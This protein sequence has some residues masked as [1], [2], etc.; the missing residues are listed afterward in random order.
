MVLH[1]FLSTG[2]TVALHWYDAGTVLVA[3]VLDS[4]PT[5]F[6][7][8]PCGDCPTSVLGPSVEGGLVCAKVPADCAFAGKGLQLTMLR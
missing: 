8:V 5:V 1:W 3:L 2:A 7:L 4:G 6:V